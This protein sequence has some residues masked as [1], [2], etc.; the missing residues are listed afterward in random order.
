MADTSRE[1]ARQLF[2]ILVGIGALFCLLLLGRG[3][4]LAAVFFIILAGTVLMNARLLGRKVAL[5]QWFE[6][7][8]ERRDAP[9]PGWGS[10]CYAAGALAAI[11][12]LGDVS[13]IAAVLFVLG[14]GDG[15]STLAGLRGRLRLPYNPKKTLEGT[16]AMFLSSLAAYAFIGPP[17]VPLAA[18][19]ALAETVP[20][21]DDNLTI[22][23]ACTAFLLLVS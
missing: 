4:M 8:F 7:R 15:V 1:D 20:G 14:I 21:I 13:Q 12:S 3:F 22:P 6:E 19:A 18:V 11:S 10:A 23:I 16:L 5:V 9:L 17:A 2:H